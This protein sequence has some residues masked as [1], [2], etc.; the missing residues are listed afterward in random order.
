[1]KKNIKFVQA[2]VPNYALPKNDFFEHNQAS[3]AELLEL[4]KT[5]KQRLTSYLWLSSF[6][7]FEA[8]VSGAL[9]EL[10]AFHGG[11]EA[12]IES[13]EKHA[14]DAVTRTH[15]REVI[16]SRARLNG[17][18]AP[19]KVQRYKKHTRILQEHGYAFPS[20]LLAAY[21]IRMLIARARELRAADIPALLTQ[22]LHFGFTEETLARYDTYR[23]IRNDIAHG[24]VSEHSLR[25]AFEVRKS[26]GKL[27]SRIDD[28][29]VANFF[30]M[31]TFRD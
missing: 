4:A 20:G 11:A 24:Q 8:Y 29:I 19:H 12:F 28:H 7:F 13:T 5:Y 9:K 18:F 26:L 22:G 15:S 2:G 23:K 16:N 27:A 6:S 25:E 21:G 14:N 3:S 17:V 10:V 30:V 31:E 1:L